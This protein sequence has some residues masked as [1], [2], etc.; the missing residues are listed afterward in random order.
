MK[1]IIYH[2]AT[3][4]DNFIAREDGSTTGFLLA[5]DHVED[6]LES[7]KHYDIVLMGK[8]TYEY[9]YK[10]GVQPGQ[11]SPVYPHMQHYIF[12]KTLNFTTEASE[13]VEV[14]KE[15]QL[16]FIQRLKQTSKKNIY[17]CGGGTFAGFL[18]DN[19]LIDELIIKLNPVI[20]GSGIKLFGTSKKTMN[21][22]LIDSKRYQS[23]VMRLRYHFSLSNSK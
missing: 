4:L 18:L 11:P 10:F 12:S 16:E 8:A 22:S 13:Q 21:L 6:Y 2:V 3:T 19:E 15:K 1:K 7:L 9:G 23:G 17:L 20:F 5:G 14:I